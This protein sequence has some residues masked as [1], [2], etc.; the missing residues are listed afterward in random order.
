VAVRKTT[1]TFREWRGE[2]EWDVVLEI[3]GR[4]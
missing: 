4:P 2:D 1:M 3:L